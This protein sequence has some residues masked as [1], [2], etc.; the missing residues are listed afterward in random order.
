MQLNDHRLSSPSYRYLGKATGGEC[1]FYSTVPPPFLLYPN[2][3]LHDVRMP[4]SCSHMQRRPVHFGP[5]VPANACSKEHFCCGVMTILGRKVK[6]R[7]SKLWKRTL[8]EFDC[9]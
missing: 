2:K 4:I 1:L 8:T 5:G 9:V 6:R 3:Q 7:R